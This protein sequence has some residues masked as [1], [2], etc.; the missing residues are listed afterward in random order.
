MKK[1]I[2]PYPVLYSLEKTSCQKRRL[3]NVHSLKG[4]IIELFGEKL[5][6]NGF[7][8]KKEIKVEDVTTDLLIEVTQEENN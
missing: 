8:L 5:M 4:V 7:D 2:I 1:F 6:K 3:S